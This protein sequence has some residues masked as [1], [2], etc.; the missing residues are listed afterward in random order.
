[1]RQGGGS[2]PNGFERR[3]VME[4]PGGPGRER[5]LR[6]MRV[7]QSRA[8][9]GSTLPALAA[10]PKTLEGSATSRRCWGY[11][12]QPLDFE[13]LA[14]KE[15]TG[16]ARARRCDASHDLGQPKHRIHRRRE[17]EG[18]WKADPDG[19]QAVELVAKRYYPNSPIVTRYRQIVFLSIQSGVQLPL[20][21]SL[22]GGSPREVAHV[23]AA[24]GSLD[25]S[26]DGQYPWCSDHK[27]AEHGCNE[28]LRSSPTV[29]C[30][31]IFRLLANRA[32]PG[33]P[34]MAASP[35]WMLRPTRI[36]GYGLSTA[37]RHTR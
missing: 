36:S 11:Q 2:C 27:R 22:D 7:I 31:G 25:V 32:R 12:W 19:R 23:F 18:I 24:A 33:G 35:T 34:L 20:I 13:D 8:L 37:D 28:D 15:T 29:Q 30:S 21:V 16:Q 14:R 4:C 1:M 9:S 26:P 5:G 3:P 10:S 17:R 6:S